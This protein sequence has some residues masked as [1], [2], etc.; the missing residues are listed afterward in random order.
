M[1]TPI[2]IITPNGENRAPF[3]I[4]ICAASDSGGMEIN[5]KGIVQKYFQDKGY[6]FIRT[7]D[8][9][10]LF[11]HISDINNAEF[12]SPGDAVE[13]DTERHAKGLVAKNI[14]LRENNR[15]TFISLGNI[16]L[17]ISNIKDYGIGYDSVDEEYEE[18][19]HLTEGEKVISALL[20]IGYLASGSL[21]GV[22]LIDTSDKKI[23]QKRPKKIKYLYVTTFQNDNYRFYKNEVSFDIEV[24]YQELCDRLT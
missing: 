4:T 9:S 24:K 16:N 6:G 18:D 23:K 8:D 3:F 5:M 15:P 2:R 17:R 22:S 10:N 12:V 13:F 14:F 1:V 20:G 19:I 11:F 21:H 7:N